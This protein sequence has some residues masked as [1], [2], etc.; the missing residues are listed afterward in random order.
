MK[1]NLNLI[2]RA[3]NCIDQEWNSFR[4]VYNS[5][6]KDNGNSLYDCTGF[7]SVIVAKSEMVGAEIKI[8]RSKVPSLIGMMGTVVLETKMTFQIISPDSKLKSKYKK[9]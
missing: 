4:Y 6:N 1:R 9:S 8:V 2:S 7:N 3:P 5:F